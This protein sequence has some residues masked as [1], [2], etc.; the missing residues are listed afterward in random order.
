MKNIFKNPI[1]MLALGLII[2]GSIGVYATIKI[3]A[4]EIGY[5]EGT[6]EDALN[7]LYKTTESRII[8]SNEY[9]TIRNIAITASTIHENKFVIGVEATRIVID[10]PGKT[11][12]SYP[13]HNE[14]NISNGYT[15]SSSNSKPNGS[16]GSM[17]FEKGILSFKLP[18][19]VSNAENTD[20]CTMY[21]Y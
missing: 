6:V 5:K 20:N 8:P 12:V 4:D 3:Q 10:C 21:V 16:T 15:K 17:S 9:V 13:S 18:W 11:N 14:W 2:A 1:F 7:D 19:V